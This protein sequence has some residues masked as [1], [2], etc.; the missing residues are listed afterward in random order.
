MKKHRELICYCCCCC[1]CP[2]QSHRICHFDADQL[3]T[4]KGNRMK[5]WRVLNGPKLK[6]Q[7]IIWHLCWLMCS[8]DLNW[9]FAYVR[10]QY[11]IQSLSLMD[12][13]VSG[14]GFVDWSKLLMLATLSIDTHTT[15][16]HPIWYSIRNVVLD[17][18]SIYSYIGFGAHCSW[19]YG[20]IGN[21]RCIGI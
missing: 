12:L 9:T 16:Q 7:H 8:I 14:Y 4:R 19:N 3:S 18:S 21:M 11:P 10:T 13:I 6:V 15:A 1:L 17:L 20:F 2:L 5:A